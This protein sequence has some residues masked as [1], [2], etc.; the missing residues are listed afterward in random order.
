[1]DGEGHEQYMKMPKLNEIQVKQLVYW[2]MWVLM[3]VL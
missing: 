3:M 2:E 1:M